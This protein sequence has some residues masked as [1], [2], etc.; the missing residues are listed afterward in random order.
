MLPTLRPS[1]H[2]RYRWQITYTDAT[3][4]TASGR[5]R[6]FYRYFN[7][8]VEAKRAL[9]AMGGV[10][11]EV[12]VSGL[13]MD[14]TLRADA[15]T[16]RV[17][18][19]AAGHEH[20]SLTAAVDR[21]LG[22][23]ASGPAARQLVTPFLD[24][25]LDHKTHEENARP[26]TRRN[27][28]DR[29]GRWLDWQ[30]VVSVG[31]ITP[32]RCLALRARRAADGRPLSRQSVKNDMAAVSSFLT[33]LVREAKVLAF[34]PLMGQRRPKV[35][36]GRPRLYTSDQ[37]QRILDAAARYPGGARRKGPRTPGLHGRAVG[38]LFLAGLRPSE[39]PQALLRLDG[40]HPE[41]RVE[42]G[43]MRGRANR[44]VPLALAAAGWLRAQPAAIVPP[45]VKERREICRLADVEWI[46]DGARHTWISAQC[47][48]LR[49]DG[50]V[51]RM[52]GTSPGMI[53]GHYHALMD[54]GEARAIA[55]LGDGNKATAPRPAAKTKV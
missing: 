44:V 15:I 54:Q 38:L 21:Y 18:L 5:A 35:E 32:E 37:C 30:C 48:I 33:Y 11:A 26:E 7:D 25:F 27:L 34:N 51:A 6:T 9:A 14:A 42:G 47:E 22:S 49:D 1:P 24:A 17:K 28:E 4:R 46:Q 55:Q 29:V 41:V 53:Y 31:D 40:H 36:R 10:V 52:A 39:V 50:A 3:R 20:V 13:Q 19:D 23:Q 12:G 45:K 2:P 16:A 8:E 43:K